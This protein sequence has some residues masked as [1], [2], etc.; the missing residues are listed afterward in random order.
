VRQGGKEEE[1]GEGAR[2]EQIDSLL[3]Y[4][5]IMLL[6]W[7]SAQTQSANPHASRPLTG[8]REGKKTS[9]Y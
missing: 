9:I 7:W 3:S 2:R 4:Q 8:H 6:A 1:E 5:R